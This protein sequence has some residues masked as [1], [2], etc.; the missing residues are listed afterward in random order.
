MYAT[1]GHMTAGI[2][3]KATPIMAIGIY[4]E[5]D[6]YAIRRYAGTSRIDPKTISDARRP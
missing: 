3:E 5:R 2:S 4:G 6:V 1:E